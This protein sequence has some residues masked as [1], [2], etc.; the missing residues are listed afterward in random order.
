M[1]QPLRKEEVELL[2]QLNKL[3]GVANLSAL[4]KDKR[5]YS[6]FSRAS[7]WLKQKGLI[8]AK[9]QHFTTLLLTKTGQ[10]VAK[11]QLPE[12]R[13][14]EFA[15]A[16]KKSL[17]LAQIKK[18]LQLSD[19]EYSASIGQLARKGWGKIQKGHLEL[20]KDLSVESTLDENALQWIAE[21]EK[22]SEPVISENLPIEIQ[23]GL[24]LLQPRGLVKPQKRT[25]TQ[26]TLTSKA[27]S[28][29]QRGLESVDEVSQLTPQLIRSGVWE[30]TKFRKFDVEAPVALQ[31]MGKK[32][33]FNNIIQEMRNIF[34][35][36]G[37]TEIRDNL[38][39]LAFWV[40][41]GLFQPQD[42]PAREMQDTFYL[43]NPNKAKLP[44]SDW[45]DHV[46]QTHEHGWKTGSSG[47]GGT[48]DVNIAKQLVMRTHTTANTIRYLAEHPDPPVKV[49][50]IDRVY[51]NEKID[52]SHAAEFYQMEGIVMDKN[53]NLRELIGTLTQF[54]QKMGF[55]KIKFWPSYFPYTEPSLQSSVYMPKLGKWIELCG[56]GIFRPEV[57]KPLGIKH[58]VLAWGGGV[59]RL[60]MLRLGIEDIRVIYRNDVNWLRSEPTCQQ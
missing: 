29:I 48:W 31:P 39:E 43:K 37:F 24:Q 33:P 54:Y 7:E 52:Y 53:V 38:V 16:Q 10:K 40:F 23:A 15:L 56:M 60:L 17:S 44:H 58:P 26:L 42:H 41:D 36:M 14:L 3:N 8:T 25:E 9:E 11:E 12:R 35:E 55:E 13:I 32:H 28:L 22:K 46:G 6:A 27:K 57:T 4:G 19:S 21:Q 18:D 30:T 51:R 59:E 2:K 45:V 34:L 1:E 20:E 50:S 5:T 47:W 49:F